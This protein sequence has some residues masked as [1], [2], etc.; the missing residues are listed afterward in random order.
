[1]LSFIVVMDYKIKDQN[2]KLINFQ[3]DLVLMLTKE[4]REIKLKNVH[5]HLHIELCRI[6][7]EYSTKARRTFKLSFF[8]LATLGVGD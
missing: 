4:K 5:L 3:L 1:M 8:S 6:Y 7:R 2:G